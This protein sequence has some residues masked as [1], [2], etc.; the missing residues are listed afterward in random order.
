V[1]AAWIGIGAALALV[2]VL[3]TLVAS[4]VQRIRRLLDPEHLR[5]VLRSVVD[6]RQAALARL[7]FPVS[8]PSDPRLAL[9]P[10]GLAL[11]YT[12]ERRDGVWVHHLSLSAAG[13]PVAA[14]IGGALCTWLARAT[15]AAGARWWR[16]PSGVH[17]MHFELDDAA[18][19]AL[20]GRAVEIPSA[21]ALREQLAA[22]MAARDELRAAPPTLA[23]LPTEAGARL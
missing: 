11:A 12:I 20:V 14:A 6:Q 13:R 23:E 7:A 2:G 5:W 19:E 22:A 9:S 17:H 1:T 8:D 10:A 4:S 15:G 16:M 3:A 18:H 21:D